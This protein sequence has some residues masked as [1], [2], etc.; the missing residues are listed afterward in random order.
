LELHHRSYGKTARSARV[1]L[2]DDVIVVFLDELELQPSERFLVDS[3]H[4]RD[5]VATR[6]HFEEAIEVT[7]RAAVE[8]ITGRRVVSFASLTK[9]DPTYGIEVFRLAPVAAA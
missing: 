1:L 7:F 8:R 9:L 3:G 6:G 5:V 4:G 2:A